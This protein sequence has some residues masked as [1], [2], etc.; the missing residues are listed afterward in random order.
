MHGPEGSPGRW[1]RDWA[2]SAVTHPRGTGGHGGHLLVP[3]RKLQLDCGA[4]SLPGGAAPTG[5]GSL[6][7]CGPGLHSDSRMG[8]KNTE[9]TVDSE[10]LFGKFDVAGERTNLLGL[11][12]SV[13]LGAAGRWVWNG[14]QTRVGPP[15]RGC[16][17]KERMAE[18]LWASDLVPS[19]TGI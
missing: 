1:G 2:G 6:L 15:T 17:G 18:A 14:G 4:A 10:E 11:G 9:G 13:L 7:V 3:T 5:A 19:K 8:V 12:A 16:P